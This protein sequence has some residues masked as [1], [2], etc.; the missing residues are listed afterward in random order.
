[1]TLAPVCIGSDQIQHVKQPPTLV[2]L[3]LVK[4]DMLQTLINGTFDQCRR[5]KIDRH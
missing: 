2:T 4:R 1:M 3:G 5:T